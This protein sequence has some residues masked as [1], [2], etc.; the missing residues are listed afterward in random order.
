MSTC[1]TCAR[2]SAKPVDHAIGTKKA[3]YDCATINKKLVVW[4]AYTPTIVV[5]E[6]FGCVFWKE[7]KEAA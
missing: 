3:L 5:P 6:G 2:R 1:L 4:G 7:R